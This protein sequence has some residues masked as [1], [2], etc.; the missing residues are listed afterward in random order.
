MA[1]LAEA[2]RQCPTD[3]TCTNNSDFH[4]Y[5]FRCSITLLLIAEKYNIDAMFLSAKT[6]VISLQHSQLHQ[7][8]CIWTICYW[9]K[10]GSVLTGNDPCV[11]C[12]GKRPCRW[13][14]RR[15]EFH[16]LARTRSSP[17]YE[18]GSRWL[19]ATVHGQLM[20]NY[21]RLGY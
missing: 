6:A 4:F 14:S 18:L 21:V 3:M 12:Y 19:D 10:I 11:V 13:L 1:K 8:I 16:W 20:M 17:S 2:T 7:L 5:S 15:S 9:V